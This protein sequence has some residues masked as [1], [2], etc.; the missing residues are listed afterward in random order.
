MF[1]L[2]RRGFIGGMESV[3]IAAGWSGRYRTAR[4]ASSGKRGGSR[5]HS[6]PGGC[7]GANRTLALHS[8]SA[9]LAASSID[10]SHPTAYS[11]R[12][13]FA[14]GHLE[15]SVGACVT[16]SWAAGSW[17]DSFVWLVAGCRLPNRTRRMGRR[18]QSSPAGFQRP[19]TSPVG[20]GGPVQPPTLSSRPRRADSRDRTVSRHPVKAAGSPVRS[21]PSS[22]R[23]A[24]AQPHLP[25]PE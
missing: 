16:C 15:C 9:G 12:C 17:P 14:G 24:I 3:V 19:G 4:N 5:S 18:G 1:A 11:L 13:C 2:L 23:L 22:T 8:A 10:F 21:R 7:V 6:T 20:S 25:Q